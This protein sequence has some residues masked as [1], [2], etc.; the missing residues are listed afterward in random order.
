MP[1]IFIYWKLLNAVFF[2]SVLEDYFN[3]PYRR[4]KKIYCRRLNLLFLLLLSLASGMYHHFSS[5]NIQ[6]KLGLRSIT[7]FADSKSI[8]AQYPHARLRSHYFR[9][10]L[11][12]VA[13]VY[14][15]HRRFFAF[16]SNSRWSECK[17]NK[18]IFPVQLCISPQSNWSRLIMLFFFL[19]FTLF[20][21]YFT[22]F[23]FLRLP[24]YIY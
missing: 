9:W 10:T 6:Q 11:R 15:L 17:I 8:L 13:R 12:G 24:L 20:I 4:N 22:L 7:C 5:T 21:P 2:H 14:F 19:I 3:G 18:G 16:H 23:L 1:L